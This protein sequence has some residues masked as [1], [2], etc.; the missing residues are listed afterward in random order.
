MCIPC[1]NLI[2]RFSQSERIASAGKAIARDSCRRKDDVGATLVVAL[3]PADDESPD[4]IPGMTR[5]TI[6]QAVHKPGDHKGRPYSEQ[7]LRRLG[8]RAAR[9]RIARIC[10]PL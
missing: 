9:R 8:K 3:L 1:V 5:F 6:G 4:K 10:P 2:E 7:C